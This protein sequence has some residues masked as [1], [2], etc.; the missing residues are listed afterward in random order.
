MKTK[1]FPTSK[2]T[3]KKKRLQN[4]NVSSLFNVKIII[5]YEKIIPSNIIKIFYSA[6]KSIN[7]FT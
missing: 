4:V 7:V 1:L 5:S 6:G 3:K 2:Y